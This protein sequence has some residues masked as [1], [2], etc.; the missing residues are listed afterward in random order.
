MIATLTRDRWQ[1]LPDLATAHEQGLT[2]FEAYIWFALF[3]PRGTPP[4]IVQRLNAAAV[5]AMNTPAVQARL[6]RDRRHRRGAR[7]PFTGLP[8]EIRG[9]RNREM[10]GTD[11]GRRHCRRMTAHA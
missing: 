4:P 10:G 9:E 6:Q 8:A 2:N 5:E 3:L 1:S 7:A 11:Q